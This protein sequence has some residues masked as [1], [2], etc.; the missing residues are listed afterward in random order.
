MA[1]LCA[2]PSARHVL[3]LNPAQADQAFDCVKPYLYRSGNVNG[4]KA[5]P[6]ENG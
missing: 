3:V 6:N 5:F 4:W 2:H 1:D